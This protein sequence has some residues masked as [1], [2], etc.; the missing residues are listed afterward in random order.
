MLLWSTP[1]TTFRTIFGPATPLSVALLHSIAIFQ[2]PPNSAVVGNLNRT[3][4]TQEVA[5]HCIRILR[6]NEPITGKDSHGVVAVCVGKGVL[7]ISI[8]GI[9]GDNAQSGNRIGKVVSDRPV[10]QRA[11]FGKL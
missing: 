1:S 8:A 3:A 7:L 5:R 10:D 4:R 11:G 2:F 9:F 6:T